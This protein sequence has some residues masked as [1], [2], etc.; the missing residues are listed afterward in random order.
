MGGAVFDKCL[1]QLAEL[2]C[3]CRQFAAGRT[4]SPF[5]LRPHASLRVTDRALRGCAI[6]AG[7]RRGEIAALRWEDVDLAGAS[8]T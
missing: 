8:S 6:Y 1:L 5:R 4:G 3:A 7:L 2:A